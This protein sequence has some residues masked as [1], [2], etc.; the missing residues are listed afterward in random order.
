V[1]IGWSGYFGKLLE[2]LG[3]HLPFALTNAPLDGGI[4]NVPAMVIVLLLSVLLSIGVSESARFNTVMVFVKLA[5]VL[6][7]IAV[8]GPHVNPANWH[9]FIPAEV[10]D[11]AGHSH[12]GYGGILTGASLIFFAYIGFDAVSTAAEETIN[13]QRNLPIG[14]LASLVIC[15]GRPST[16]S[17]LVSLRSSKIVGAQAEVERQRRGDVD[18]RIGA[19]DDADHQRRGEAVQ[20]LAA[21]DQQRD[22]HQQAS[23]AWSSR[24]A[25]ASG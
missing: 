11:A 19:G 13:P 17:G 9:P 21:E 1:A 15:T 10:T 16:S 7:F 2:L 8:A 20:G 3:L 25:T 23:P 24:Y 5:A 22:D 6:I 18:R 14:I 4:A 12:F